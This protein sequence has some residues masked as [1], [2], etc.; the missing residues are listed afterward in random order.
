MSLRIMVVLEAV[1]D[2]PPARHLEESN[3]FLLRATNVLS[4]GRRFKEMREEEALLD[5]INRN[6]P[7][8]W[9]H[10][11][12]TI[13]SEDTIRL[14]QAERLHCAEQYV[15]LLIYRH[16]FSELVAERTSGSVEEEQ[17]DAER[18]ALVAAHNSALQIV[19]AHVHIAKKGLMTYCGAFLFLLFVL[20]Y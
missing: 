2:V 8:Y 13:S 12:E 15:R 6:I 9:A 1:L 19:G 16:R 5:E 4:G 10:S 17:T 14:T 20:V 18:E 11:P 7:N 3:S